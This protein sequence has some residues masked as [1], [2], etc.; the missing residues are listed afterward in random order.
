M[1]KRIIEGFAELR[2]L[3]GQE[4]GITDWTVIDQ[5]CIDAFAEA[6]RDRQWIH[7]DAKRAGAELPGG[8]TI[9]HGFLT[10]SLL[11]SLK[12]QAFE[13][14]DNLQMT[15]NYGL[16]RVRFP[17]PVPSGSRIRARFILQSV[18]DGDRYIQIC[19]LATVELEASEK[20]ALAAE[21]LLRYYSAK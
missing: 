10:L 6:S 3:V 7:V 16:N 5:S 1:S 12:S 14:R 15:I 18:E 20:P 13:L 19:L 17:S 9:A 4:L 8:S 2:L 21:W 11:S